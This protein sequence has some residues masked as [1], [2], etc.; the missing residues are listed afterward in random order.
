M[1]MQIEATRRPRGRPRKPDALV[2]VNIR[3]HPKVAALI[4]ERGRDWME[5]VLLEASGT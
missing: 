3:L 5:A 1:M 2:L 4:K